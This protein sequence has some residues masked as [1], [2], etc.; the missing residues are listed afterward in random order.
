M[1]INT[2]TFYCST[3]NCDNETN[4]NGGLCDEHRKETLSYESSECPG[5]G[6]DIYIGANGYCANCWVERFGCESQISHKCSGEWDHSE[7][8]PTFVCDFEED[9]DCPSHRT[10]SVASVYERSCDSC[11][12]V[13]TSKVQTR[14]C[15]ECYIDAAVVI[16]KWWRA[17]RPFQWCN[18][19]F[20]GH[21]RTCRSYFPTQKE[22]DV[23]CPECRDSVK[24]PNLPPS[25]VVSWI[26]EL[27][28]RLKKT[29]L[30]EYYSNVGVCGECNRAFR[31]V[32]WDFRCRDCGG[33][34]GS[35]YIDCD[36]CRDEVM[37]QQGHMN[38][39]GCL[40][41]SPEEAD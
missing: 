37:N 11:Y 41:E 18:L 27:E 1:N 10:S 7:F 19:W 21:C 29:S 24:L 16:Q 13:F 4:Y 5:C 3:M 36:G 26:D 22:G 33:D 20:Q 32:N 28:E 35:I 31:S 15:G 34:S 14:C 23:Y 17:R 9:P 8:R 25:P 2:H 38:L 30:E 12:E 6:N 40:Y 39:G